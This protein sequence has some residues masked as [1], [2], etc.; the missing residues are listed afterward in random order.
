MLRKAFAH[1]EFSRMARA[2]S[3]R[4]FLQVVAGTAGALGAG[5]L[6]PTPAWAAGRDPQPIPIFVG[7]NDSFDD[8]RIDGL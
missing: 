7:G 5:W 6:W 2:L 3:R 4:R 1:G 8:S